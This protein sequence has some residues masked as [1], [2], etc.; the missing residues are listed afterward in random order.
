MQTSLSCRV[1]DCDK[2]AVVGCGKDF[3]NSQIRYTQKKND[4]SYDQVKV[5]FKKTVFTFA[6]FHMPAALR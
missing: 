2:I 3:S 4:I 1:Y 5:F 6:I